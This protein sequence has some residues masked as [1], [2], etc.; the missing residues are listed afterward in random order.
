M[1]RVYIHSTKLQFNI[2]KE[3]VLRTL[4]SIKY[5]KWAVSCWNGRKLLV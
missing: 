3:Y 2:K 4:R 1:L 5:F